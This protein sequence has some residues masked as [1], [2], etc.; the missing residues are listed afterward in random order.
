M[1]LPY[2]SIAPTGLQ[3]SEHYQLIVPHDVNE[4]S[5]NTRA[6]YFGGAGNIAIRNHAGTTIV[7]IGLPV[8]SILPVITGKVLATGTTAT[9]LVAMY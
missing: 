2:I 6:I 3:S 5:F 4:L 1:A 8:G 7:F 9:N